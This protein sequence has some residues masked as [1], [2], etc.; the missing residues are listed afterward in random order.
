M[1]HTVFSIL[2]RG[3]FRPVFETWEYPLIVILT[4]NC[5]VGNSNQLGNIII[6]KKKLETCLVIWIVS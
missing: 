5:R 6:H 4:N 2:S 1:R 3:H